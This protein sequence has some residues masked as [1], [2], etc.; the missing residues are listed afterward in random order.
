MKKKLDGKTVAGAVICILTLVF[1]EY[2]AL[3]SVLI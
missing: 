2:G 3:W 1:P